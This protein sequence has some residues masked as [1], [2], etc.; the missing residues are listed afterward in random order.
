[1][2][3]AADF[4]SIFTCFSKQFPLITKSKSMSKEITTLPKKLLV[5]S[6]NL[7]PHPF[8]PKNDDFLIIVPRDF[9]KKKL[10]CES[11]CR[12]TRCFSLDFSRELLWV[13]VGLIVRLC[14]KHGKPKSH[15]KFWSC[16]QIF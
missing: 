9:K 15:P 16:I 1:M 7:K 4:S 2:L 10:C 8:I 11:R 3:S 14:W 6:C 12:L 5:I 13:F